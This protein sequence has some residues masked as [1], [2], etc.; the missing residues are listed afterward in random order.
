MYIITAQF[1][2]KPIDYIVMS[3]IHNTLEE[4]KQYVSD[5]ADVTQA[6]GE[7]KQR[8]TEYLA[9][10]EYSNVTITYRITLANIVDS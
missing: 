3:A 4:A 9:Y 6:I 8:G 7:W 1:S 5:I 2:N 10:A